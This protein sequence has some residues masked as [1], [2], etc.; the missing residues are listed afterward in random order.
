MLRCHVTTNLVHFLGGYKKEWI[1]LPEIDIYKR[2]VRQRKKSSTM[3][4]VNH[5]AES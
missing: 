4:L 5:W 1:V 3:A 2:G